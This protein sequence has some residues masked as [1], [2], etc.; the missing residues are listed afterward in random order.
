MSDWR[1]V[2]DA[3]LIEHLV[4]FAPFGTQAPQAPWHRGTVSYRFAFR[5][6]SSSLATLPDTLRN[7]GDHP[8][9]RALGLRSR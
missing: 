3:F 9:A 7:V 4:Q 2:I 1:S 5:Y 8:I 6:S